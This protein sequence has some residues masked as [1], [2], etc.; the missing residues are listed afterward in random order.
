MLSIILLRN[1]SVLNYRNVI[2]DSL[3]GV[4]LCLFLCVLYAWR[5]GVGCMLSNAVF[6][7]SVLIPFTFS[8]GV[9][10]VQRRGRPSFAAQCATPTI[11]K[12]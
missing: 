2:R 4:M 3:M 5:L 10:Y 7:S 6:P 9:D 11:T 8:F 12:G 1:A